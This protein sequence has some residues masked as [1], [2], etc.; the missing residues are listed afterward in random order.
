MKRFWS[1]ILVVTLFICGFSIVVAPFTSITA[2]AG[3]SFMGV[4]DQEDVIVEGT[5]CKTTFTIMTMS[6]PD[7]NEKLVFE[8]NPYLDSEIKISKLQVGPSG[9]DPNGS[10]FLNSYFYLDVTTSESVKA[11]NYDL[12]NVSSTANKK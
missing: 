4:Y 3:Y 11:G 8:R 10:P 2:Q 7:P 9:Y 5:P 1:W 6:E 12:G